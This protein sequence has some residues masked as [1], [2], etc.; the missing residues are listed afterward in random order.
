MI[1]REATTTSIWICQLSCT[2]LK[3]SDYKLNLNNLTIMYQ[4]YDS[5]LGRS[6]LIGKISHLRS[7]NLFYQNI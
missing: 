1:L 7:N 4:S 3:K 2:Y 6:E 5:Y